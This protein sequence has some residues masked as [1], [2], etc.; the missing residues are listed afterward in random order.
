[1]AEERER[2]QIATDLHDGIT[3]DLLLLKMKLGQMGK[4]AS[5][6][7]SADGL[8]QMVKAVE[9]MVQT[10]RS[11]MFDLSPPVLYEL[12]FEPAV[13]WLAETTREQYGIGVSVE[14]DGQDK[15]LA[16]AVRIGLFRI[17][18][19]LIQNVVK[20]AQAR[21]IEISTRRDG[22]NIRVQV[23]DDGIGFDAVEVQSRKNLKRGFGLFYVRERLMHLG[24]EFELESKPGQGT[25]ATLMV[26]IKQNA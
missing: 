10:T 23:K 8:A 18:R 26:P 25:R 20:H 19:E 12:G 1:M 4:S 15:P 21:T 22:P 2:R 7:E 17:M 16:E 3:Q 6:T 14:D 13:E 11:L 9:K 5:S 24:G